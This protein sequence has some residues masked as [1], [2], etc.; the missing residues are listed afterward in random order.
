MERFTG[1]IGILLILGIAF[2]ASNNR[3][4]INY[5]LVFSGLFLQV[6]VNINKAVIEGV[7]R[8]TT[9]TGRTEIWE[10]ALAL[11]SNPVWG[12]GFET[13]WLGP[14]L[15][16]MWK[17]FPVFLPNQAHNGYLEMYLNLGIVGL[18]LFVFALASSYRSIH[19]KL[20]DAGKAAT[21]DI[22]DLRLGVFGVAFFVAYL[23]YNITEATYKPLT[24]LFITFLAVTIRYTPRTAP[25]T[26][27]V[28]PRP[29]AAPV[30]APAMPM[31]S[32]WRAQPQSHG[33]SPGA[34]RSPAG[35]GPRRAGGVKTGSVGRYVLDQE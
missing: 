5:R 4:A 23:L 17:A 31:V 11:V 32:K 10:R 27:P 16:A 18:V 7:G 13:F 6:A 24:F 22:H 20:L 35:F 26:A 21:I 12:A 9:L 3:K 8:D 2:L 29:A 15:I 34:G 1:F 28:R 33:R 30:P 19:G 14:R 25:A